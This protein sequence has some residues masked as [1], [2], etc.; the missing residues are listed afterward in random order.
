M[1]G[2]LVKL[3]VTDDWT[4]FIK[5]FPH[6]DVYYSKEYVQLFADVEEGLPEAV[7][8]EQTN[9]KI[10]YPYIKRKIP[11]KDGYFD[12]VTPYGYGGPV[13]DG[14]PSLIK[15]FYR[16]FKKDCLNNK[17]ITETVRLHPL[18]KNAEYMKDVMPVD[19]IRKTTAV[20]LM[21]PLEEIKRNYSSSNKRN[22]KK[23]TKKGIKIVVSNN[24]NDIDIFRDLYYETMDRN[25][26]SSYYYF[27]QSFFNRQMEDTTLC[28][29]YLLLAKY[30]DE[31]IGGII[32]LIG[33]EYAHY[34]LGASKTEY[35]S[36]R[37]NNLLFDAMIEFS[38]SFGRKALHLGGGYKEHDGLFKFKTSFTSNHNFD[39]YLG[40]NILNEKVYYELSQMVMNHSSFSGHSNYFPLY[41]FKQ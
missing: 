26:A 29:S 12:I 28:S 10:F 41:R 25:S 9:G 38:H 22:I 18:L 21:L 30:H 33:K 32:L 20:D 36:L 14:D 6:L 16:H 13:I 11:L 34:H 3:G 4:R 7:Y 19:Y 1:T 35:L 23:A 8:Y 2:Q 5:K 37:P 40:K 24:R 17:I 15:Q 31:M 27:D 39:Y